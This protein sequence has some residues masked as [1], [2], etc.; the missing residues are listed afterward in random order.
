MAVTPNQFLTNRGNCLP[1]N[2]RS[3]TQFDWGPSD[4]GLL[5]L[6]II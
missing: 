2:E 5:Q 3:V 1:V 6:A 4:F